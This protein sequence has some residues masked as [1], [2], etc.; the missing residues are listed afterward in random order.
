MLFRSGR[1]EDAIG[2]LETAYEKLRDPEVAGHI[3]E[4]LLSLDRS[5]DA[6]RTLE[7]AEVLFPESELLINLRKQH[8]PETP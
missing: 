3:V 4:V 5:E 1:S 7:E 2:Y 8:F 6:A